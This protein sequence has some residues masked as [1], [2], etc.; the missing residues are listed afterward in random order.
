MCRRS[1]SSGACRSRSSTTTPIGEAVFDSVIAVA[2]ILGD[3]KRV[4]TRVFT[5][6]QSHYLF[7]DRFGRPAKGNDVASETRF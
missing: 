1:R 3:G 4:R 7:Q 2:K 5:E 6:L